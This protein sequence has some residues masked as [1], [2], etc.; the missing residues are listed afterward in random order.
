MDVGQKAIVVLDVTGSD[1]VIGIVA[2]L[3][4]GKNVIV[5]FMQDVGL[6]IESSPVGHAEYD[7]PASVV[8]RTLRQRVEKGDDRIAALE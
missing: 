8:G 7:F 2:A 1:Q 6:N 4:L 5:G 3:K